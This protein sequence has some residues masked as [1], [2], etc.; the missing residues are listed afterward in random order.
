MTFDQVSVMIGNI[1]LPYA[2]DHF[3]KKAGPGGPPFICYMFTGSNNF[4]ADG[5]VYQRIESLRVELYTDVKN[6]TIEQ[7][8][9]DALTAAGIVFERDEDYIEAERMHMTVYTTEILF[10]RQEV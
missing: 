6:P 10:D 3:P 5:V 8:V 2:Y 4:A 7:Q 1:G 9:E